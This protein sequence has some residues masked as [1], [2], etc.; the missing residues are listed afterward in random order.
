[1]GKHSFGEFVIKLKLCYVFH[2]NVRL[3]S[4]LLPPPCHEDRVEVVLV[5]T[6]LREE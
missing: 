5:K 6:V 4:L 3:F 1:M 2:N